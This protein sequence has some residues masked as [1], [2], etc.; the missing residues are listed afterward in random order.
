MSSTKR[1]DTVLALADGRRLGYAEF[2]DPSGAPCLYFHFSPGSRL[3][4][5]AVFS[6][7]RQA[8][9]RGVRLV[10]ADRPGF[11][12]SDRQPT[13]T[14]LDWPG[15]IA[16]LADHLGID[17]FAVLGA[18]GGGA[19]ALA[20]A[21]LLPARLT[22]AVVVSG[23]GP[24]DPPGA[25][26]GMAPSNRLL[27]GL[28]RRAPLLLQAVS[29]VMF[30]VL[31]RRLGKPAATS[32][33]ASTPSLDFMEDPAARPG[34]VAALAEALRQGTRGL[35][36]EVALATRPW[37]FRPEEIAVPVH[38]WHG[39]DDRNVPADL[40][41]GVAAAIPGCHAVF[42][43]GGHTAPFAHLDEILDVVRQPHDRPDRPGS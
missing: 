3:E 10:S 2:G 22:A 1:P 38:L 25:T 17:R 31:L 12:L 15:D 6:G 5:A 40:A 8:W 4:P 28:G 23:V 33:A 29:R 18:S 37:G 11:G 21:R 34:L 24:L 16:A 13:R 32:E 19:Y 36:D 20:C 39:Q 43:Q 26:T 9:L 42:V 41:R 7:L 35:V 30:K 14:L 27:Y